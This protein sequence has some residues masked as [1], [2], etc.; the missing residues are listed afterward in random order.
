MYPSHWASDELTSYLVR[1]D[2][3]TLAAVSGGGDNLAF[4]RVGTGRRG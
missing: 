3:S 2:L 1:S 4:I